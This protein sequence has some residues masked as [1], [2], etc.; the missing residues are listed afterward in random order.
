[1]SD[2]EASPYD[3]VEY[4]GHAFADTHPARIAAVGILRGMQPATIEDCRVLELGCGDGANLIPMA[5]E[6]PNA[7]FVGIDLAEQPITRGRQ[8]VAELGLGNIDLRV[9]DVMDVTKEIG[10]FDYIIAHGLFSW[11]PEVVRERVLE[12]CAWQLAPNGIAFINF[13]AQ[14]GNRVREILRE[15]LTL[16]GSQD[17]D[18]RVRVDRARELMRLF[19]GPAGTDP[20]QEVARAQA[21]DF[22][23]LPDGA[24]Y[25]DWLA[26]INTAMYITEFVG[27]AALHGL[28]F[29]G[30]A[31][32][33][34]TRYEHDPT[35][36]PARAEL[37]R[38]EQ[39][40]VIMKEQLLD[41]LRCRRF[42]QTL[43]C[44]ASVPLS[45]PT[46]GRVLALAAASPLKLVGQPNLASR[47]VAE[48]RSPHDVSLKIDHP[49]AKAVLHRLG[50]E[51]PRAVPVEQLL[52]DARAETGRTDVE[53]ELGDADVLGGVLL[54]C[55]GAA[56]AELYAR[57]PRFVLSPGERPRASA[58]A[59]A[60]V[61]RAHL[62]TTLRHESLRINDQL[63][64]ALLGL[65]DGT[66]ERSAI[67]DALVLLI[68]S[69]RVS[70]PGA[71][72]ADLRAGIAQ[73]LEASLQGLARSALLEA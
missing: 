40:D 56:H 53:S 46:P 65:L 49:V 26:P 31:E 58:V 19:A 3:V 33:F 70:V 2:A 39:Q 60:E 20:F 6:L 48:F 14:P 35:L 4:P 66:R 62:V 67:A 13:L 12:I 71:P 59:R 44:R 15:L 5:Y 41:F 64:A 52:A 47:E 25:H 37:D 22:A 55:S 34:M 29:V 61:T 45:P 23:K 16:F 1:M 68:E 9:M 63:G 50:R 24:I 36:A 11:V 57:A 69:G 32:Y 51:W 28:A 43:L 7:R 8:A 54:A 42:R 73:G 27:H 21:A 18:P 17:A 30:E 72:Q 10:E 38:L